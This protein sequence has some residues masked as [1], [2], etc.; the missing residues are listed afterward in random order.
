MSLAFDVI[1]IGCLSRNRFW[2]EEQAR[3]VAHATCV[4]IR[5]GSKTVLVDP[6]LPAELL[7]HRLDERAGLAAQKLGV[8]EGRIRA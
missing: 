2:N 5:D 7:N 1:N 3:R 4:L 8:A 6:S